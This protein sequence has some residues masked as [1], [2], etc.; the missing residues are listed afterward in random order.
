MCLVHIDKKNNVTKSAYKLKWKE[1]KRKE[2]KYNMNYPVLVHVP[3]N[4][5]SYKWLIH[6]RDFNEL[7]T[8]YLGFAISGSRLL[9]RSIQIG[10]KNQTGPVL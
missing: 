6:N 5:K 4:K 3:N 8:S 7:I 10:P 9:S 1:K 2:R